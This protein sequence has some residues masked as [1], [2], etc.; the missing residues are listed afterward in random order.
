MKLSSK[1]K[2]VPEDLDVDCMVKS[3]EV[4]EFFCPE[5]YEGLKNCDCKNTT[6][7]DCWRTAIS[8]VLVD[9]SLR[10]MNDEEEK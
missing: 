4:I 1:L 8:R 7:F 5:D 9:E 2:Y 10:S 6:C 3:I